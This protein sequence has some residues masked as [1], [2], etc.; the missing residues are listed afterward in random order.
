[1]FELK[2]QV[3]FVESSAK[4]FDATYGSKFGIFKSG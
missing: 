2:I 4:E 3:K 1:M